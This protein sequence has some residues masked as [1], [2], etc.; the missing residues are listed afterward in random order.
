MKKA[1]LL[2]KK[3][4]PVPK[5]CPFCNQKIIV[6]YK[7]VSVLKEYLS[8]RGKIIGKERTG[9]CSKH[10]QQLGKMIK[11]ARYLALL[12]YITGIR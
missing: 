11:R 3:L 10:Q 12:P 9:I 4:P 7:E 5:N 8:E 6:D 2:R 1:S